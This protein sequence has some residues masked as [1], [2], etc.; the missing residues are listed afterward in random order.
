MKEKKKL[1]KL[2][3]YLIFSIGVLLVYTVAEMVLTSLTGFDH[4]TLTT[5]IF[6]AFGGEFM[7]AALI[8]IYNIRKGE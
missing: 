4:S 1:S 3:R 2:D 5:C 6:S 7:L 8:K